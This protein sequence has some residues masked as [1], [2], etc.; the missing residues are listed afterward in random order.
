MAQWCEC[1]RGCERLDGCHR[2]GLG[3]G[4]WC[5]SRRCHRVR[6]D[7]TSAADLSPSSESRSGAVATGGVR[8]ID[9]LIT[10]IDRA[11]E[12]FEVGELDV[13]GLQGRI[14]SAFAAL[15]H[16]HP[17]LVRELEAL[18]PDLEMI[19]FTVP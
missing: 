10:G 9:P 7:G 6:L 14:E 2:T 8:M 1:L 5:V 19:R 13:A 17:E 3:L 12:K 4:T 18:I 11:V 15:D 16:T